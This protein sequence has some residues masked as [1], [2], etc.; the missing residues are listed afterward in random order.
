MSIGHNTS[1]KGLSGLAQAPIQLSQTEITDVDPAEP[2]SGGT[3]ALAQA[4]RAS[5]GTRKPAQEAYVRIR[6]ELSEEYGFDLASM[7]AKPLLQQLK[8]AMQEGDIKLMHRIHG[9]LQGILDIE[10]AH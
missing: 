7:D 1:T 10:T 3:R 9:M 8:V 6:S 5:I 4:S 2:R